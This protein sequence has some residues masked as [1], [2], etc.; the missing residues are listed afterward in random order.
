MAEE[1]P[2]EPDT[3]VARQTASD[4]AKRQQDNGMNPEDSDRVE[5]RS[6]LV[7]GVHEVPPLILR[8]PLQDLPEPEPPTIHLKDKGVHEPNPSDPD[9]LEAHAKW[10]ATLG[11]ATM[12]TMLLLGTTEPSEDGEPKPLIIELGSMMAPDKEGWIH[13]LEAAGVR[14]DLST[15]NTR[16]LCWLRFYAVSNAG[17][18]NRLMTAIAGKSGVK[19]EDVDLAAKAFPGDEARGADS[20]VTPT[21][22]RANR[23]AVQRSN[24]RSSSRNRRA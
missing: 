9:Y 3:I 6:G 22:N 19:E 15:P 21:P 10:Q 12:D 18:L 8:Q 16:Y 11:L 2:A 1:K 23:R 13:W 4:I 5:F 24:P 20:T 7:L 14:V 17:D